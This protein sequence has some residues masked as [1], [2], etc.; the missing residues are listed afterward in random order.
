MSTPKAH[1]TNITEVKA[2]L[3]VA[4]EALSSAYR[5]LDKCT[6]SAVTAQERVTFYNHAQMLEAIQK[7]V[8][9]IHTSM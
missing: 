2:T 9:T 8:W 3:T 4:Y 1:T 5:A 6:M 7:M